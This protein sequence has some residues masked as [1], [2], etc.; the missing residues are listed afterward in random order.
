VKPGEQPSDEPR[1][2]IVCGG[3]RGIGFESARALVAEGWRVCVTGRRPESLDAA[4]AALTSDRAGRCDDQRRP[5]DVLVMVGKA[6]DPGHQQEVVDAVLARWGRID[7]LVNNVA[8]SPFLGPL[9]DAEPHHLDR[10]WTTNVVTPW[11]W[12]K[13]V[14]GAHLREHGGAIVNVA[15]IG[16]TY[17]VPRVG[18]YNI[19]KAAL[20]HLT[21]QLARELA[22]AVRVNAV[23]PATIRTDF[24]RAKYEGRE[25]EV[26][27]QYPL[28]RLGTAPEVGDAVR[29]LCD[30]TLS[31]MTGQVMVLDGGATLVQGVT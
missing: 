7:A 2:A 18:V 3:S 6:Q 21:K 10:A 23:A 29:L 8:T 27:A 31:W 22:P 19:T 5:G 12:S 20:I 24:S 30:N 25:E 11:S 26:A 13:V 28:R 4:L 14:C 17:P 9:L 15:S 1:V 16:G